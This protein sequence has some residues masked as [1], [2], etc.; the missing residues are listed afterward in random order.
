M[1]VGHDATTGD[2]GLPEEPRQLLVVPHRKLDVPWHYPSLL[3]VPRRVPCELQHL[4][5]VGW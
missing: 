2:R 1:D 3:V 5:I 4:M